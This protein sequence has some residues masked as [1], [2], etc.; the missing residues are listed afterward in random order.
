M[1]LE[2]NRPGDRLVPGC[3]EPRLECRL[4]A[5]KFVRERRQAPMSYRNRINGRRAPDGPISEACVAADQA[6]MTRAQWA[7][8]WA[9]SRMT[10]ISLRLVRLSTWKEW[11][12]SATTCR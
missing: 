3:S 5:A 12:P 10:S 1:A 7:V 8:V 6:S 2:E 4:Q 9:S 11:S